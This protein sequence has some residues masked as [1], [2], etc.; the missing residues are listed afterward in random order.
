MSTL[1]NTNYQKKQGSSSVLQSIILA[2]Y[3]KFHT[4]K[5]GIPDILRDILE[6]RDLCLDFLLDDFLEFE[7]TLMR[8]VW[9]H[10]QFVY[11][12]SPPKKDDVKAH[13][14]YIL[15]I[16]KYH[17]D[18]V[19]EL[20]ASNHPWSKQICASDTLKTTRHFRFHGTSLSEFTGDWRDSFCI[21]SLF[22]LC[23]RYNC[24]IT[25][26]CRCGFPVLPTSQQMATHSQI[27]RF[28]KHS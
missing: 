6:L 15:D 8:H 18:L 2:V 1:D 4:I 21:N 25:C 23:Q 22:P 7:E 16:S 14:Q 26:G 17:G 10:D 3:S 27:E 28:P 12:A 13:L 24:C 19:T 9:F 5:Q 20:F 11:Q